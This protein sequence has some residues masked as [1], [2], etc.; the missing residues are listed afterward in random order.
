VVANDKTPAIVASGKFLER[1]GQKFFLKATRL[2]QYA[3]PLDFNQKLIVLKRF[4]QLRLGHTTG[5]ILAEAHAEP[6]LGLVARAG[7]CA[8]VEIEALP[9]D[10]LDSAKWRLLRA[11]V[12]RTAQ[13][14]RGHP[15][16]AD[17][18]RT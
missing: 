17:A 8:L 1:L 5:V 9:G 14:L 3:E 4:E 11:R 15:A 7:L 13:T 16:L 2:E 12:A 6:L 10:L 18:D